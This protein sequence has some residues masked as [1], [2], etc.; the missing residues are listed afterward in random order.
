MN[1]SN[2]LNLYEFP[3]HGPCTQKSNLSRL[4]L[5]NTHSS[6]SSPYSVS[7]LGIVEA[8]IFLVHHYYADLNIKVEKV[9][10]N[11]H[12]TLFFV[13]I[14]NAIMSCLLYF[15]AIHIAEKQ[16]DKLETID[17][18][19]YVAVRKEFEAISKHMNAIKNVKKNAKKDNKGENEDG[20][21]SFEYETS[22]ETG[23]FLKLIRSSPYSILQANVRQVLDMK[24]KKLLVQVR[25]HELRVHFIERYSLDPKFRVSSY[26]RLCMTDVFTKL[27]H[28]TTFSWLIL[29]ASTN[30]LFF[31]TGVI[32][33]Q[34][35]DEDSIPVTLSWVYIGY[36]VMFVLVS[37]AVSL[38][39]KN[40][41]F[42]IMKN[43]E[44][45]KK[46]GKAQD[47][48]IKSEHNFEDRRSSVFGG[49][50]NDPSSHDQGDSIGQKNYFW[51]GEPEYIVY[52][53][54][55]MQFG[56]ALAFGI[57]LVFNNTV[58]S[59][60]T[61]L[62]WVGLYVLAPSICYLLFVVRQI[63]HCYMHN[64]RFSVF[65]LFR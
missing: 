39:M 25:F 3:N 12:F 55:F 19:H 2:Q 22:G 65:N 6:F 16:W 34:T 15:F 1:V 20:G 45:I 58:L 5:N 31:I 14:I 27:V 26:L 41:F 7:T 44:W 23:I 63:S 29:L 48:D 33:T 30:L 38:K 17:L 56:Y 21:Q 4:G 46:N 9:F 37:V 53:C 11:V 49:L 52:L 40:I 50:M 51:G 43:E 8:V 42:V 64:I 54:Q 60:E 61:P 28:I 57:L 47:E 18:D 62:K 24:Y 36:T 10:A 32:T 59:K 35:K 13:A